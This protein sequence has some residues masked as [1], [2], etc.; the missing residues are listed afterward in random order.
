M[1]TA[2]QKDVGLSSVNDD[3][4]DQHRQTIPRARMANR[5][6]HHQKGRQIFEKKEKRVHYK[7]K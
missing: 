5:R 6:H 2:Q 1:T 4:Q 7:M 3:N